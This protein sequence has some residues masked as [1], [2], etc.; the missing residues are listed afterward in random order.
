MFDAIALFAFSFLAGFNLSG[1][2]AGVF[3]D[4]PAGY[5]FGAF[6]V[7]AFSALM[8]VDQYSETVLNGDVQQRD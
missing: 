6:A 8:A 5:I 7:G 4:K 3:Q 2:F 1:A